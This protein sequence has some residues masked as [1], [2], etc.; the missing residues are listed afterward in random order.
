MVFL[1]PLENISLMFSLPLPL[2]FLE[3]KFDARCRLIDI[4]NLEGYL[5]EV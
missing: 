3:E 2:K 1:L 5:G 4:F